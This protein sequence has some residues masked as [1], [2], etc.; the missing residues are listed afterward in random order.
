MQG[1]SKNRNN[2]IWKLTVENKWG[3]VIELL[4]TKNFK[5]CNKY[6]L[7]S[8]AIYIWNINL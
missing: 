2:S 1:F 4:N 8:Y 5:I 7:K 6:N 3:I